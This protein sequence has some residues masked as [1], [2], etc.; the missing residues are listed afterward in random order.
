[1]HDSDPDFT[2]LPSFRNHGSHFEKHKTAF[3]QGGGRD[4][5]FQE[6]GITPRVDKGLEDGVIEKPGTDDEK[7]ERASRST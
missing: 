2:L 1:V 4:E 7:I 6:D 3:E 5:A